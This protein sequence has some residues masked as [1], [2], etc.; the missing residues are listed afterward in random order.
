MTADGLQMDCSW[1]GNSL[2]QVPKVRSESDFMLII[3]LS[4]WTASF[5]HIEILD[6]CVSS[7]AG[8][9]SM[10]I[11]DC[12]INN[13]CTAVHTTW[14]CTAFGAHLS[15]LSIPQCQLGNTF[16]KDYTRARRSILVTSS[17]KLHTLTHTIIIIFY[18]A[19]KIEINIENNIQIIFFAILP[20]AFELCSTDAARAWTRSAEG[21]RTTKT[22]HQNLIIFSTFRQKDNDPAQP[23]HEVSSKHNWHYKPIALQDEWWVDVFIWKWMKMSK[24]SLWW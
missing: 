16:I 5:W 6:S 11:L 23:Q 3:V 15:F 10:L 7:W 8:L 22:P 19:N 20:A 17:P 2:N 14:V 9:S 18:V 24:F 12:C 4:I 13:V 1:K 21:F